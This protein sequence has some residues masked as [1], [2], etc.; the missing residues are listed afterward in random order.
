MHG[1]IGCQN[2]IREA[3]GEQDSKD[4]IA[5]I[6]VDDEDVV[7]ASTGQGQKLAS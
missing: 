4:T 7:V 1:L 3:V 6:I 2:G 5:I